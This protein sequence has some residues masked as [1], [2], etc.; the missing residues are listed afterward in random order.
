[1]KVLYADIALPLS[2]RLV[3]KISTI[4]HDIHTMIISII[5][6]FQTRAMTQVS[7]WC[8]VEFV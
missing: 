6:Y 7:H 1:M 4:Q 2:I 8:F 3:A 5:R